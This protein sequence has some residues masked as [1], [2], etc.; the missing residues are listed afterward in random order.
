MIAPADYAFLSELLQK[1]SGLALGTGKEYLLE[2]RLPPVAQKHG[3]ADLAALARAL[4]S[5][6]RRDLIKAVCDSMT[7]GETL[8]FRDGGPW[9]TLK[10]Q[11]L[12]AVAAR[13]RAE[14]R[15]IR[16]WSAACSS[17]QEP[18]SIAMTIADH[19][20]ATAGVKAEILATDYCDA[21]LGRAKDGVYNQFEV[22]RGLPVMQLVKYFTQAPNGFRVNDSLRG[23]IEWRH[24]NLLQPF[25]PGEWDIIFCRNVLIYFDI[26]TKKDIIERMTKQLRPGGYLLLG[27][28]ETPFGVTDCVVRHP[29]KVSGVYVRKDDA[30]MH[31]PAAKVA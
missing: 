8:W 24:A 29:S 5:V 7:T 16:I 23:S 15:P 30:A 6:P 25:A 21:V 14:R 12:P 17:G 1:E 22:Q 19:P 26:P 2:S 31:E 28:T 9:E 11:M 4:R 3:F 20:S 18:Y 27:G 10:T 13:A